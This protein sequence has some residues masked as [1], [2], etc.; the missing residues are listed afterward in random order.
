MIHIRSLL[1]IQKPEIPERNFISIA[2]LNVI[3]RYIRIAFSEYL[4]FGF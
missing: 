1:L 3:R 4:R 2:I